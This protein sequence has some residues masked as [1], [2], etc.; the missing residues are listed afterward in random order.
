MHGSRSRGSAKEIATLRAWIDAGA[1][2]PA[3]ASTKPYDARD[4][5]SLKPLVAPPVPQVGAIH[6]I[7]A[8]VGVKLA[9]QD[10][11]LGPEAS[12]A[13]LMRRLYFDLIGLPPTPEEVE[14]FQRSAKSQ[15]Y[16]MLVDELLASPRYGE[17]WARHWL[18]VVHYG[19]THGYDKDRPRPNAWP[20]SASI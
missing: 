20:Y 10:L 3:S 1:D 7:D 16:E 15:A 14:T 6:P 12:G 2:W 11:S 13:V 5:W 18:D 19:E 8:F 4:W 17:R 9:E